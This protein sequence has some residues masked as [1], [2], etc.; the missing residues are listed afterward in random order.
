MTS[1]V[2]SANVLFHKRDIQIQ[3]DTSLWHLPQRMISFAAATPEADRNVQDN[4]LIT[5]PDLH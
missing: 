4:N 1:I 3:N 5:P 2:H